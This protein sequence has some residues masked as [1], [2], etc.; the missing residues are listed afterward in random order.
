M[1]KKS[2]AAKTIN[3]NFKMLYFHNILNNKFYKYKQSIN[4]FISFGLFG[5]I[6]QNK[7]LEMEQN[8]E[9]KQFYLYK[10]NELT[11]NII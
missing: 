8:S 6:H 9:I 2:K 10:I 5:K 7:S 11:N 4:Y 3:K 1:R